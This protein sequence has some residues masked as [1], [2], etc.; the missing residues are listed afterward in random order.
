MDA[1]ATVLRIADLP[2]ATPWS[3]PV[4]QFAGIRYSDVCGIA[5]DN[6]SCSRRA[7]CFETTASLPT[8]K[9]S[10]ALGA[11]KSSDGHLSSPQ[12]VKQL[13]PEGRVLTSVTSLFI[14][15]KFTYLRCL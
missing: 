1:N 7:E 3:N 13:N 10:V 2:I 15:Y 9:S 6:C 12:F 4:F 8:L 5:H 14:G 11:R